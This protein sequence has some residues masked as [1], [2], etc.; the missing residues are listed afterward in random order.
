MRLQTWTMIA[1]AAAL[2][3][4]GPPGGG[5][6]VAEKPVNAFAKPDVFPPLYQ[7]AYRAE[8]IAA[9]ND[10]RAPTT[11]VTIYRDGRQTRIDMTAPGIGQGAVVIDP[12]SGDAV[13]LMSQ[14]DRQLAMKMPA[15]DVP[16]TAEA[17][18]S[19]AAGAAFV[20]ACAGAGEVGGEWSLGEGASQRTA[21]VTADGIILRAKD[22]GRIV[23]ETT[24]ISRGAQDAALFAVP[25]GAKI[26]DVRDMMSGLKGMAEKMKA[27]P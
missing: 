27:Q 3:A 12:T 22:G 21:C 18:W 2:A 1:L 4:C 9:N 7:V 11:P 8:A 17:Q 14:A 6:I 23:W 26:V 15:R 25:A 19:E 24:A 13:F 16:K 20:G 5:E 10:P